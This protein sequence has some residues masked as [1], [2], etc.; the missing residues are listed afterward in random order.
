[1][2]KSR[3]LLSKQ[4]FKFCF[5][6]IVFLSDFKTAQITYIHKNSS[7]RNKSSYQPVYVFDN[8]SKVFGIFLYNRLQSLGHAPSFLAKNQFGFRKHSKIE[9]VSLILVDRVLT[10]LEDKKIMC[11]S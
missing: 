6:S 2:Q 11:F 5:D 7:L 4:L 3:L 9:L 10:A 1:M 8:L